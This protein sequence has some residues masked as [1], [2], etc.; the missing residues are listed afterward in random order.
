MNP[1]PNSTPQKDNSNPQPSE[2][3]NDLKMAANENPRANAN[4]KQ[5]PFEKTTESTNEA[6]NVGTEITDGE[7]G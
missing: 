1:E 7:G 2:Q 6:D 4:I 5:A 3:K